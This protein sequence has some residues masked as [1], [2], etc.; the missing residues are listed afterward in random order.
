VV[1]G[2]GISG[3]ATN[4]VFVLDPSGN[5]GKGSWSTATQYQLPNNFYGISAKV[6]GSSFI[7]SHGALTGITNERKETYT[8]PIT[9]NTPN[10]FGFAAACF[11]KPASQNQELIVKNLLFTIE[12]EKQYSLSSNASWLKITKNTTGLAKPSGTD[13]EVTIN[14]AGLATGN[15]TAVV[16]ATGTGSGPAFASASFC[17]NLSVSNGT[18]GYSL[19]V[20]TS[21]SGTVTKNPNQTTYAS[22]S[23][24][25]LT[26]TPAAGYKFMGWSGS[27]T[28]TTN[29]LTVTMTGNKSITATFSSTTN[30]QQITGY[31][32][33]NANTDLPI[34]T[35]TEGSII[36]LALLPT[37]NLNIQAISNPATVGSVKYVLTGRQAITKT[38]NGAPYALFGDSNGNYNAWVPATGNY[39]LNTTPYTLS[40][41]GG[42]AGTPLTVNF[43]V[44]DQSS[45]TQYS[46]MITNSGS[47]TVTKN[48]NQTTY[49]SGS[50]VTLT[51]TPAAGYKFMGWSGSATGTTNPLTVTM[52]SNKSVT[53]TFT[54]VQSGDLVSNISANTGRSY[55]LSELVVGVPIYTD[56]S[57]S[58]SAVPTFLN[59]APF[60]RTANDDKANRSTSMLTFQLNQNTTVYI[61]YDPRATTL[62]AW[63]GGWQKLTSVLNINDPEISFMNLYSKSYAAGTVSLGG[64]LASPAAGALSNYIVIVQPPAAATSTALRSARTIS[65][66]LEQEIGQQG[67]KLQVFPNP[68]RP[69]KNLQV[70]IA[71][72]A[73][74]EIVELT[75]YDASGCIKAT[76]IITADEQ[77]KAK[78]EIITTDQALNHGVYIVRAHAQSGHIQSKVL[79]VE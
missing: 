52:T 29:P 30:G 19:S 42:T 67:L 77:G 46:L 28:G 31:N 44:I 68:T 6:V 66:V 56:R 79:V 23:S 7:I 73:H 26:A 25:T 61:A 2:Q 71:N 24:V 78:T 3:A 63:L 58:V 35:I 51:A 22:G 39:N 33:I 12:G 49:A 54:Q 5:S 32:L 60:I 20:T 65:N 36:N 69:G 11:S 75:L 14:A 70:E 59:H 15:Y 48:P 57:H 45:T 47:G 40:D 9:R 34:Q 76:K 55:I 74:Q 62:P 21:G 64:N 53:A 72:F 13:I 43:S 17:V 10:K 38:E 1:G 18:T 4:T 37:R 50:S 16:T 41:G 8:S 27:A